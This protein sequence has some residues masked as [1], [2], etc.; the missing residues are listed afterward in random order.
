MVSEGN[1]P[2]RRVRATPSYSLTSEVRLTTRLGAPLALGELGWMST[3]IVDAV[4]VGRMGHSAVAISAS[5]LGNSLFYAIAFFGVG[6]LFGLDTLVSQAYGRGEAEDGLYSLVQSLFVVAVCSPIVMLLTSAAPHALGLIHVDPAIVTATIAYMNALRWSAPPLLLYMAVRHYLQAIDRTGWIMTSL[7]TANLV[8]WLFD[9][10]LIYGHGPFHAYGI[11]GSGWATCVVRAYMVGLLLLALGLSLRRTP[12]Q[13]RRGAWRP[14]RE[15]LRS[16][17]NIGWPV[18]L[19][20]FGDL[21]LS[22]FSTVLTSTLGA[23]LLAAH[24]V[25]LDL[26]A[27]SSMI[28]TG[29]QA[30]AAVRTGQGAGRGDGAQVRRAGY[31]SVAITSACMVA[32]SVSFIAVPRLWA[33]IYT[34]DRAVMAATVPIFFI[35][36]F[37]R[38]FDGAQVVLQGALRGMGETRIPLIA[39][40]GCTWLLGVPLS[41]LLVFRFHMQLAGVW[42][43]S[44]LAILP[45]FAIMVTAWFRRVRRFRTNH[46]KPAKQLSAADQ[47]SDQSL[48]G[49]S[50]LHI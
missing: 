27:F 41:A 35:C 9:W 5:S 17:F 43:G 12:I 6:L 48:L 18:G 49:T 8:N 46:P 42:M 38:V 26:N 25:V 45:L 19:Q 30:A 33:S 22:S 50:P 32:A 16:I 3:Y 7:L 47:A 29:I 23:T 44:M 14:D 1:K 11:A 37:G 36:A 13:L 28:P 2:N 39:S 40:F 21:S 31:A 20:Q 34:N 4:M 15:R 24:Q 10:L